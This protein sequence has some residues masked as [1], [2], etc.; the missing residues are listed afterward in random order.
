MFTAANIIILF[1]TSAKVDVQ[2]GVVGVDIKTIEHIIP[3]L[4]GQ[5]L[6]LY[7]FIALSTTLSVFYLKELNTVDSGHVKHK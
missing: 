3:S 7:S 5:T 1:L 4:T 6:T 2:E